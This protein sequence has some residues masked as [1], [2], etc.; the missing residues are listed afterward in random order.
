[1]HFPQHSIRKAC[2][3]RNRISNVDRNDRQKKCHSTPII[4][5][6]S[7]TA[8]FILINNFPIVGG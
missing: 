7:N 1:M 4:R 2:P 5:Q 6:T 8:L 3:H